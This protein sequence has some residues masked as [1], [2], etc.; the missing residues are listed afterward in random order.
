MKA[1]FWQRGGSL[2]YKNTTTSTIEA[3]TV[4]ELTGR[5]GI[6][7]N[8]ILPGATGAL[9]MEGVFE[10]DKATGAITMGQSLY[11][12]STNGKVTTSS[13]S[14]DTTPVSYTA[15]GYAAEAATSAATKA[16]VKLLG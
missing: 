8:D 4:I 16:I 3:N 13:Q 11:Y 1:K 2:D 15:I 12:D 10:M 9:V 7:G 14:S 6:V 5:C